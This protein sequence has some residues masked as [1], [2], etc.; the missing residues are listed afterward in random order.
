MMYRL[1]DK[2]IEFILDDIQRRGIVM[3][4]LRS[5][6]LDHICCIIENELEENG[7]FG[8]FYDS[9]IIRFYKDD[10]KEL[11]EEA[12]SL[13]TFKNYYKM[14]KIMI[15]S[16]VLASVFMAIGIV[17]KFLHAPGASVCIGLSVILFSLFFLPLLL[18]LRIKERKEIKDRVIVIAGILSGIMLSLG[19]WFKIMH[20]PG[21]NMLG[22]VSILTIIFLYAPIYF[23]TNIRRTENKEQVIVTSLVILMSCGLFLTLV[24]SNSAQQRIQDKLT[25]DYYLQEQLLQHERELCNP[26]SGLALVNESRTIDSLCIRIKQFILRTEVGENELP[27]DYEARNLLIGESL[28]RTAIADDSLVQKDW[29]SL[30]NSM[31]DYN[32]MRLPSMVPL[33]GNLE[34]YELR[35][36]DALQGLSR[37]QLGLLQNSRCR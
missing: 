22:L 3:E 34:S 4:D 17:F 10:L 9:V 27:A 21:A 12:N 24:R 11:E 19:V 32:R 2:Q 14:K 37:I 18:T 35:S 15:S 30:R 23:F 1:S 33:A 26:D 13:L 31:E 20:W 5:N 6:L 28:I 16:G 29:N 8:R 7:D 25:Q 36:A